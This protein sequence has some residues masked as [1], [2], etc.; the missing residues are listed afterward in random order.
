MSDAAQAEIKSES[1]ASV[2]S[3]T[4]GE[5]IKLWLISWAGF[6]F[7]R[8]AGATLRYRFNPEPGCLSDERGP[9]IPSIWCFWHRSVL[10]ATFRFRNQDLAVM[11]SRSFDGEYIARI[12]QKLGFIP[13]RGSSSR[14][15]VG[16]LIG[17]RQ[18]LEQG[19]GVVFT[20][21]GP[22]GP[23]YVAKPGPVLL[24]KKTGVPISCFY[25]AVERAWILNSWDQMIIPKPFSRAVIYASGP[26]HV[27]ADATE[28]QMA[29]L[30]QQMQETLERCRM[31]AE[32]V[33]SK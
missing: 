15:A 14:G 2:R 22:R 24:A 7:I 5:R 6:L 33:F 21:D 9:T 28:E 10:P 23:R 1:A 27:S 30:H 32:E 3:F 11:T 26:I 31:K 17:M 12:I 4:F 29:A 16:A 19:H 25:V 18:Q 13:V 8:L 20:I